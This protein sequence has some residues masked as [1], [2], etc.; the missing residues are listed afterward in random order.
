M[1]NIP[2]ECGSCCTR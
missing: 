1:N 2:C